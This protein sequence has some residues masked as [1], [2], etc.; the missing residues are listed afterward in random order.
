M[1]NY[2]RSRSIFFI[3]LNRSKFIFI[4]VC[5]YIMLIINKFNTID[6]TTF[7][8]ASPGESGVGVT[9]QIIGKPNISKGGQTILICDAHCVRPRAYYHR[10]KLQVKPDGWTA[11]G[12]IEARRLLEQ[13][14]PMVD[15]EEDIKNKKNQEYYFSGN[16]I[17]DWI[18]QNGFGATMTCRRDLLPSGIPAKYWHKQKTS[19]SK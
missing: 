15:G 4:V 9:F 3:L 1:T 11:S 16:K 6:E 13:L 10:H 2:T 18:G 7:A 19:T 8:T 12:M 17:C 5:S 14:L